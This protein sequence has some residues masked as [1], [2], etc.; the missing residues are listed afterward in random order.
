[1]LSFPLAV[2]PMVIS[3]IV[4]ATVA[5]ERIVSFLTA[6]ELQPDAVIRGPAVTR[7]GEE[8][9]SIKNGSFSWN[10]NDTERTVLQD[11]NFSATKGELSCLVGR[12][13]AG[14]SSFLQAILGDLWKISGEVSVRGKVAYVPQTAW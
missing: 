5:S 9:V 14:K 4:E 12:V 3:A 11:I 1:M 13:G 10:K 8:A 6:E 2:L 7:I